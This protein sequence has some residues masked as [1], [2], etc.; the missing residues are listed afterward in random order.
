MRIR[1]Y[2]DEDAMADALVRS[3]LLGEVQVLT[4]REAGMLEEPDQT[5]LEFATRIGRVFYS[6]NVGHISHLH[7]LFLAEGKSHAGIILAHQQRFSVG[8]QTRGSFDSLI[9]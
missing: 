4:A 8:E 9:C 1:L 6:C 2:L 5:Q 7:A 3:L